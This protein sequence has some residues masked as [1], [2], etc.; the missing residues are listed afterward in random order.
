MTD[1]APA[2][3]VV[4]A[5]SCSALS[6]LV[7]E[8]LAG[9]APVAPGWL[10]IE[11]PGPWGRKPVTQSRLDPELGALLEE[12]A[13]TAGVRVG[14]I[15]RPL[16]GGRDSDE[17]QRTTV[18]FAWTDPAGP[19]LERARLDDVNALADLDLTALG[20]GHRPHL[21]DPHDA[22]ILLVCSN[23]K[24]DQCCAIH[25]RALARDLAAR[26]LDIWESSHLG[27]HR[28]APTGVVLPLGYAYGRWDAA[29]A[30]AALDAAADGRMVADRC[31]GRSAWR[32]PG[33]TAEIAVRELIGDDDP[34]ALRISS[35]NG[36]TVYV[37]HT[38][39]RQWQVRVTT[40]SLGPDRT[41]PCADK[42]ITPTGLSAEVLQ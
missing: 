33:Q 23:A 8:P 14:L 11:Q 26:G 7:D 17:P 41:D 18:L 1:T 12:R 6:R 35:Y 30:I 4:A 24:R 9:T 32:R 42:L 36:E 21:G 10:C 3:Q 15:R 13:A 27:G 5:P 28:F 40:E 16:L 2:D 22:P 37:E 29:A 19:W 39:G 20:A 25:G 34:R 31:R 38:D